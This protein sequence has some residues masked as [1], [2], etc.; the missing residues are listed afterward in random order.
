MMDPRLTKL[1]VEALQRDEYLISLYAHRARLFDLAIPVVTLLDGE[2]EFSVSNGREFDLLMK[3]V[4]MLIE[5]RQAQ[6]LDYYG[7]I[8]DETFGTDWNIK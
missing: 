1:A 5:H 6:I 8:P 2:M 7:L 4:N 3:K